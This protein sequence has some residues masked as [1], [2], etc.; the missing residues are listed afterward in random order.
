MGRSD[1][2][3]PAEPVLVAPFPAVP[4]RVVGVVEGGRAAHVA[5]PPTPAPLAEVGDDPP[6][7]EMVQG[8]QGED[9]VLVALAGGLPDLVPHLLEFRGVLAVE[10][11]QHPL[12]EHLAVV[13]GVCL[14]VA[15]VEVPWVVVIG[16]AP[17]L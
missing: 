13:V 12:H 14:D 6:R 9:R 5:P 3:G 8:A 1:E 10:L 7:Q 16:H 15:H 2:V 11:D 4:T 17:T